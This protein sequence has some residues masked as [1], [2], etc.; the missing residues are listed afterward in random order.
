MDEDYLLGGCAVGKS[1]HFV[2]YINHSPSE[3]FYYYDGLHPEHFG[4]ITN[5]FLKT[6]PISML[7][8]FRNYHFEKTLADGANIPVVEKTSNHTGESDR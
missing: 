7:C 6:Y 1:G 4:K 5:F 8:Y 2:A 3:S